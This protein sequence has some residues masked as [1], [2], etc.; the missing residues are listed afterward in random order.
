MTDHEEMHHTEFFDWRLD[1]M[2]VVPVPNVMGGG[3]P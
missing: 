1:K 2:F 3:L